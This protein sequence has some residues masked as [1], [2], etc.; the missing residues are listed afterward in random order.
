[1]PASSKKQQHFMGMVH[2]LQTGKVHSADLPPGVRSKIKK[3]AGSISKKSSGDFAKSVEEYFTFPAL[4]F[5]E[6]LVVESELVEALQELTS[7]QLTTLVEKYGKE[8]EEPAVSKRITQAAAARGGKKVE[9]EDEETEG[10][11]E[12][13]H[14]GHGDSIKKTPH[15]EIAVDSKGKTK[16]VWHEDEEKA[17][18]QK[19]VRAAVTRGGKSVRLGEKWKE[20]GEM[21]ETKK[22]MFK[23]WTVAELEAELSKLKK[24]GPH[25]EGSAEYTKQNEVEF[26]LRA[27]HKFGKVK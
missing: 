2:A 12:K 16:S 7:D 18:A 14:K 20:E 21:S 25:K 15:K 26:A 22:G 19:E 13:E 4:T 10:A 9:F 5:K 11:W 23:D 3:V 27:K 24:S 6:Y 1:M 8:W 17:T